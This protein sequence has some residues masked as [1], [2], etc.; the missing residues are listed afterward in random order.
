MDKSTVAANFE[1][2]PSPLIAYMS[3]LRAK[4]TL[5]RGGYLSDRPAAI[6]LPYYSWAKASRSCLSCSSGRLVEMISKS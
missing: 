4:L 6:S 2:I 3:L 5:L 1:S